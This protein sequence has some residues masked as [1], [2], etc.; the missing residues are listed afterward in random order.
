MSITALRFYGPC[1]PCSLGAPQ[2]H[3]GKKSADESEHFEKRS[4]DP[5]PKPYHNETNS[6]AIEVV[7]ICLNMQNNVSKKICG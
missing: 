1:A 7:M 5:E 3:F 4:A 2:A 6:D